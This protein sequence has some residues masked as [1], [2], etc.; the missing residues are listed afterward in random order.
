[1]NLWRKKPVVIEAITFDDLVA[2]GVSSGAPLTGG[3]P[4]SFSYK[5]HPITHEN[6]NCYLIPTLEG[7]MRFDRGDMLITGVN[8]EI[9]PCKP[10]IFAKT[11]EQVLS[12]ERAAQAFA[13]M[14]GAILPP[15]L[16]DVQPEPVPS[17]QAWQPYTRVQKAG[18]TAAAS[19]N[20]AFW[21][22]VGFGPA[23]LDDPRLER[24][25]SN[26][27]LWRPAADFIAANRDAPA[28]AIPIHLALKRIG[29][30]TQ[31]EPLEK[32][33]WT[34]FKTVFLLVHDAIVEAERAA[35]ETL[36]AGAAT[37]WPGD[38][39]MQPQ[40]SAFDAAGFSPRR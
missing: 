37:I 6:D 32:T 31:P 3:M 18:M 25:N 1:M 15:P 36:P 26:Y 7:T 22:L 13:G 33:L 4:W 29:G 19:M 35:V 23:A 34:V 40:P 14:L 12:G 17:A 27:T 30:S 21:A 5:G 38:L 2:H 9:Y 8:G 10:D 20:E 28:E 39:A 11:Y 16:P 24:L